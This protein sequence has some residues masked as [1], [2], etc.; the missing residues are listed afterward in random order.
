MMK[1]KAQTEHEEGMLEYL[2]DIIGSNRFKGP[3][4]I[5]LQRIDAIQEIR[6]EK[7]RGGAFPPSLLVL[8]GSRAKAM[9]GNV[10]YEV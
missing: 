9:L 2:E 6:S 3:I 1:S 8:S 7:V 4:E 10:G 5:L